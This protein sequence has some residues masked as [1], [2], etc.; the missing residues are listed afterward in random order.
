M[1]RGGAVACSQVREVHDARMGADLGR[2]LSRCSPGSGDS[3][4]FTPCELRDAGQPSRDT[5]AAVGCR[6]GFEDGK[7]VGG[8]ERASPDE[9]LVEPAD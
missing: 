9:R 8:T 7:A 1:S 2:V 6:L 3:G 4:R 5:R